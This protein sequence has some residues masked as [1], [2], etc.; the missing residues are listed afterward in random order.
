MRKRHV[1]VSQPPAQGESCRR[2]GWE[3]RCWRP[4]EPGQWELE[5]AASHWY[6]PPPPPPPRVVKGMV[7]VAVTLVIGSNG[8]VR[9]QYFLSPPPLQFVL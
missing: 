3:G 9:S 5:W 2:R 8:P 6:T 4:G 7:L 1:E